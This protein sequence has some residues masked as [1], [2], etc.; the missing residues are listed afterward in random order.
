MKS[1]NLKKDDIFVIYD[2]FGA[3]GACRTWSNILVV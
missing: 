2:D 1:Q 3:I